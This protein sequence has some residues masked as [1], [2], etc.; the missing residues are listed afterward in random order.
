MRGMN[1]S[2]GKKKRGRRSES[3][4]KKK[5]GKRRSESESEEDGNTERAKGCHVQDVM[6]MMMMTMVKGWRVREWEWIEMEERAGVQTLKTKMK[7]QMNEKERDAREE[8]EMRKVEEEMSG[9]RERSDMI[10]R[11]ERKEC[12]MM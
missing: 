8:D 12:G 1:E 6:K 3:E 5:R 10:N 7:N 9:E 2:E 4:G 11:G